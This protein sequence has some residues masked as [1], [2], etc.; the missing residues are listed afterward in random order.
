M[1]HGIGIELIDIEGFRVIIERRGQG[2]LERLFTPDEIAYCMQQRRSHE[3][4]AGRFAVKMSVIKAA[5][6][7]MR[8]K[9]R[10]IEVV[11]GE[12]GRP[13]IHAKK[14]GQEFKVS[15]SISHDGGIGVGQ[16]IIERQG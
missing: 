14:L 13:E 16:A 6:R 7:Q 5:G 12:N 15:V 9:F 2:F 10:D 4:F 3:H 1:I 8:L 11:R